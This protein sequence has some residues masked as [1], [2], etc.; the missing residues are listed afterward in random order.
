LSSVV[1]T[2][3]VMQFETYEQKLGKKLS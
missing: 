1:V 2:P 3:L